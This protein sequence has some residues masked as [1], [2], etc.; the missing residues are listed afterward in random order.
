MAS[1]AAPVYEPPPP[2]AGLGLNLPRDADISHFSLRSEQAAPDSRPVVVV[3]K[4]AGQKSRFQ[5]TVDDESDQDK[6]ETVV[7]PVPSKP[8]THTHKP[9]TSPDL[10]VPPPPAPAPSSGQQPPSP[11]S[12]FYSH[13]HSHSHSHSYPPSHADKHHGP[14]CMSPGATLTPPSSVES[15]PKQRPTVHFS[16][17]PP[18]VLHHRSTSY[19]Y[20]ADAEPPPPPRR[21]SPPR[22]D[23]GQ[24]SVVD[25]QWGQL[26][27]DHGEPTRRLASV[28]RGLANYMI[29]EYEPR[30]SLVIPPVKM[31]ALY[32]RYRLD[33][34]QFPFQGIFDFQSRHRLRALELL[35]QDLSCEY[36]LIQDHHHSARPYI[37]ALTP[38]GLQTWLTAFIQASPDSE[39]Y[40]LQQILLDTPLEADHQSPVPAERLPKQLSR[41]LFPSHRNDRIYRDVVRAIDDWDKC[42]GSSSEP[43]SPSWSN[44]LFEAF[45][46]SS[47]T[48]TSPGT[49]RRD[50][51]YSAEDSKRYSSRR[52]PAEDVTIS[53]AN[54]SRRRQKSAPSRT[55]REA[56]HAGQHDKAHAHDEP[57]YFASSSS[58]PPRRRYSEPS[59]ERVKCGGGRTSRRRDK[60]PKAARAESIDSSA[61]R[62]RHPPRSHADPDRGRRVPSPGRVDSYRFFQGRQLGSAY[63]ELREKARR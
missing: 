54:T 22:G 14:S 18:V 34:E 26:F 10:Q 42:T 24:L 45:R 59:P 28:L 57:R 56:K 55:P 33:K 6:I 2:C 48:N 47:Q 41:H 62:H 7:S 43:P 21:A 15:S 38:A 4:P 51:P 32:R 63:D 52:W 11:T 19:A 3:P 46:G 23:A 5:A 17:R 50:K 25:R 29:R 27:T 37:P 35:Y 31:F 49:T 30:C 58:E 16:T 39:S 61:R 9:S 12:Y 13:S 44:I 36:H 8:R 40:R 60:S 53:P 1:A 20:P